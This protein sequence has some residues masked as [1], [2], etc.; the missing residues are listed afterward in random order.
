MSSKVYPFGRVEVVV[1]ASAKIAAWSKAPYKIY[2]QAGYPNQPV[3]WNLLKSGLADE[4]YASAALS[5]ATLVRIEA[6]AS[7]VFYGQGTDELVLEKRGFQNQPA[8]IALDAT[9]TLT[10]AMIAAGIITSTTAAAV[11]GTV[12]TGTVLDAALQMAL[13]E[14]LDFSVIAT[15][16]NAF[17]V[18]AASG[19]TIVGAA[20]VATATSGRFRLRKTAAATYIIYRV[21]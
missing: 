18:T 8:P 4:D 19:V 11:A 13:G 5:A 15:G 21:S 2:Q 3:S 1:A 6:G 16:A 9:G 12:P 10:A 17:T 20:A 14:S 7:E